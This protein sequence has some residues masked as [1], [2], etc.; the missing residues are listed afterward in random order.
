M[1]FVDIRNSDCMISRECFQFSFPNVIP[2]CQ[3]L[4]IIICNILWFF[5]FFFSIICQRGIASSVIRYLGLVLLRRKP[6]D[7][8]NSLIEQRMIQELGNLQN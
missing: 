8:L 5:F 6:L 1:L 4:V 7:K 3:I 2:N